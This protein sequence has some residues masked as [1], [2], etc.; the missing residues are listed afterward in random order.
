MAATEFAR[1]CATPSQANRQTR[2]L[3]RS[4]KNRSLGAGRRRSNGRQLC[5]D[6][7]RAPIHHPLGSAWAEIAFGPISARRLPVWLVDSGGSSSGGGGGLFWQRAVALREKVAAADAAA[8]ASKTRAR[9][10]K[11]A[12]RE[13]I[14]SSS[15][16]F[17][18]VLRAHREAAR[19]GRMRLR[20]PHPAGADA[21]EA[22]A[23]V[24]A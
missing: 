9:H 2:R 12:N 13:L 14:E 17:V 11:G 7:S 5:Q 24:A 23:A 10:T 4:G 15:P 3:S 8:L 6:Q 21:A 16:R 1:R 22:A 19:R 18:R 20:R